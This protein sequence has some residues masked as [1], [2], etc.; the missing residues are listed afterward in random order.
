MATSLST[1]G[2]HLT[3][4]S[5]GPSEPTNQTAS[6]SVQ[7]FLHRWPQS[8]PIFYNG[9]PLSL[10]KIAP[11]HGGS[12]PP[13][14]TWFPEPTWGLNPNGISISLAVLAEL[15]SVTD[16][17]TRSVTI[18]RIYIRSTAMRSN[19]AYIPPAV[20]ALRHKRVLVLLITGTGDIGI[21]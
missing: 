4:D 6:L 7:P 18:V 15:T 10:L 8:V 14:N 16:H 13:S 2:P 17:A 9:T 12:G 20:K 19:N 1:A 3:H 11:S 5:L 21:L